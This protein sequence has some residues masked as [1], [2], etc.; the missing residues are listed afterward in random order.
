MRGFCP[1][2]SGSKGNCLYL[3]TSKTKIL[4]D[5]G[6][7]AKATRERLA[8]IGV[9]L[10]DI[11]AILITHEHTDHIRG[12]DILGK[13]GIPV[14]ANS[15]T[16]EA[17]GSLIETTPRY[18]IF[19]TG[20]AFEFGDIEV[21]PF[22]IQHDAI[23]PVAFVFHAENQKIGVCADLGFATSL[24]I[25]HLLQCAILY[26]EANHQ[27]DM[28][29]ASARSLVYKMRVLSRQGHLSNAQCA[30]LL[31]RVIHPGLRHIYLAHLSSECNAPE[32]AL[33]IARETLATLQATAAVS[34]A[35]QERISQPISF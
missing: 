35:Y 15:A 5:A 31:E 7:T 16:V 24:V 27:E 22:S 20:E 30:Q 9:A 18:K 33:K 25:N 34:I 8:T 21:H 2:A 13:M 14:L 32:L 11:D 6:L 3:G 10:E 28:V 19:T 12:L 29:H 23:D 17:L 1:L 26:I 4:I